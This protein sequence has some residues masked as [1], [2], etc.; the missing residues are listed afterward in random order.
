MLSLS[1]GIDKGIF[2]IYD[3][4][5]NE[6]P[7]TIISGGY[8]LH[9]SDNPMLAFAAQCDLWVR[10]ATAQYIKQGIYYPEPNTLIRV[11]PDKTTV[12]ESFVVEGEHDYEVPKE[13]PILINNVLAKRGLNPQ[14]VMA[15][16]ARAA[17]TTTTPERMQCEFKA[18][19]NHH[20]K[21]VLWTLNDFRSMHGLRQSHYDN[22]DWAMNVLRAIKFGESIEFNTTNPE[23]HHKIS[24]KRVIRDVLI[25]LISRV[26]K[27]YDPVE[28]AKVHAEK[29]K[30]ALQKSLIHVLDNYAD[31][32]Y[33]STPT[34]RKKNKAARPGHQLWKVIDEITLPSQL[35]NIID[36]I[37]S[38]VPT[39]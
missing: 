24:S 8:R 16:D 23:V 27:A 28:L 6:K 39:Q 18:R 22:R 15:F 33:Q 5:I 3:V 1:A 10:H 21:I 36:K 19:V 17:I 34:T 31:W 7:L 20:Q 4:L 14:Q 2:G 12:E 37:L 13:M 35:V 38:T 11:R 30:Q 32:H 26:F 25:S 29:E 9:E